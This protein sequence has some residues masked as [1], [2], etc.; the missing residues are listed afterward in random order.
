M[1]VLGERLGQ[2]HADA[3]HLEVV[4]VGVGGEQFVARSRRSAGPWSPAGTATRRPDRSRR[5]GRADRKKSARHRNRSRC[6]R[7]KVNR[8][9]SAASGVGLGEHDHVVA[10]GHRREVAVHD[11]GVLQDAVG[12]QPVEPVPQPRPAL[13]LHQLLVA[14]G[15]SPPRCAAQSPLA[16]E[17]G[18]L[19]QQPRVLRERHALDD[20]GAPERRARAPARR[21]PRRIARAP[22]TGASAALRFSAIRLDRSWRA[23]R[24]AR[25]LPRRDRLRAVRSGPPP[26]LAAMIASISRR[27]SNASRA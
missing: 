13:G 2:L 25:L 7:G 11:G 8:K 3:V 20:P 17:Q 10:L 9:R 19:V 6:W 24:S 5:R 26:R 1:P 12:A 16:Q 23:L 22:P 27:P 21:W 14:T 4:A 18:P 15:P